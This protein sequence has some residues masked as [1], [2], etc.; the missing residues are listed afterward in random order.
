MTI[1]PITVLAQGAGTIY[2]FLETAD[3]PIGLSFDPVTGVI[4]GAP[5]RLGDNSI[6]VYA[7]DDNGTSVI[8]LNT[9]TI[10]PRIIRKQD[11][12]GAY[13]SLVRQYTEVNAAINARDH[14]VYPNQEQHLGE[15]MSP[16]APDVTTAAFDI[17]CCKP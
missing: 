16:E 11:G 1:T 10:I 7:K 17:A 15:F 13:T 12:A 6:T 8:V 2:Y 9:T 14:L 5:T 3:L 4:S